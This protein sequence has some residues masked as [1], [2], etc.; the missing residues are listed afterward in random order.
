M[1]TQN[2]PIGWLPASGHQLHRTGV[3]FDAV[4]VAGP[5]GEEAAEAVGAGPVIHDRSGHGQTY[6]LLPPGTAADYRWPPGSTPL[7]TAH[8]VGYVGVPA[9]EGPT[10][11]LSWRSRPTADAPFVDAAVLHEALCRLTAWSPS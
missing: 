11:P 7:G 4:R 10:W 1:T 9:L 5:R 8:R 2:P 6:F 3:Q